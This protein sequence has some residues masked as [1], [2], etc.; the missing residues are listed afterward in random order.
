M[1]HLGE[2][3]STFEKVKKRSAISQREEAEL[4]FPK[5]TTKRLI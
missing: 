5:L 4:L 3:D 2:V 1:E